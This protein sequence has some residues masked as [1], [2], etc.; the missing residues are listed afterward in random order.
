[1]KNKNEEKSYD[2]VREDIKNSLSR[3]GYPGI[4][5]V[6]VFEN[7]AGE[8]LDV[9]LIAD[10]VEDPCRLVIDTELN[11]GEYCLQ[12]DEIKTLQVVYGNDVTG[13]ECKEETLIIEKTGGE[14]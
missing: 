4:V 5:C 13:F 8:S 10:S 12:L 7:S 3:H 1:M 6:Y 2:Q 14:Q 11:E 9:Y